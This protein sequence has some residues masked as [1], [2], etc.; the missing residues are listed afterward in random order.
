MDGIENWELLENLNILRNESNSEEYEI[1]LKELKDNPSDFESF[2][3][4]V[5][6]E[7]KEW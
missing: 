6:N 4:K 5:K 3:F 1:K 2:L 7:L